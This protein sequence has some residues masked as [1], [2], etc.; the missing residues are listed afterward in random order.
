[1]AG[2]V[3]VGTEYKLVLNDT[4]GTHTLESNLK[5]NTLVALSVGNFPDI[6]NNCPI[7]KSFCLLLFIIWY[8]LS[9]EVTEMSQLYTYNNNRIRWSFFPLSYPCQLGCTT[10]PSLFEVY[11]NIVPS[12][13]YYQIVKLFMFMSIVI[14]VVFALK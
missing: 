5:K 8:F 3:N 9:L 10:T 11:C 1:M 13:I 6:Q 2:S 7:F 14:V 4:S 12:S